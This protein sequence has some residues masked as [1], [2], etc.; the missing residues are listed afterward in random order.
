MTEMGLGGG[1]QCSVH[2]GY[3]F[4]EAD[5]F[6]E[7]I[8]PDTAQ[9]VPEGRAGEVVFTTL[10][11]KAMPL[12]RYRTGDL[13]RFIPEPCPCGTVLKRIDRIRGRV[14][15]TV[16]LGE[17]HQL[18]VS[19]LD[20]AVF[21]VPGLLDYEAEICKQQGRDHLR[22]RVFPSSGSSEKV[23]VGVDEALKQVPV[24]RRSIE[25]EI[26]ILDPVLVREGKGMNRGMS[27][28]KIRDLRL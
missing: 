11:R 14:K 4:R 2:E 13:A 19:D 23:L 18:D 17:D 10:T 16:A 1:V 25:Q 6:F 7:I 24:V 12:I 3:H 21:K 8:D 28:R 9:P 27:K 15:G 20:E 26:L 22:I 5:F